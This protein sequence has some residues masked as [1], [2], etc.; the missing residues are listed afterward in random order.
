MAKKDFKLDLREMVKAGLHFGHRTSKL[1]PKM[2]PFIFGTK[3]T[4][5]IIDLEKTSEMFEKTLGFINKTVSE[6]KTILFVGTK[7]PHKELV[8]SLALECDLPYVI[9]RW[10]GGTITNFKVIRKRI[11]Y[12]QELREKDF[13][14]YTKKERLDTEKEIHDLEV[15]FGGIEKM[16]KLPDAVFVCDIWKDDLPVREAKRV[17]IPVI[18][19]CDTNTDPDSVDWA[20]PANDDAISSVRYMLDKIQETILKAKK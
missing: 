18:A 4:V 14:G 5:H 3:K 10:I 16:E 8:K 11:E 6:G 9:E 15:K 20:I 7:V 12:L 17:G 13:E 1:H 2:K 19:I